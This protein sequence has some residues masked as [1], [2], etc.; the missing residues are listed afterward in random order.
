MIWCTALINLSERLSRIVLMELHFLLFSWRPIFCCSLKRSM[1]CVSSFHKTRWFSLKFERH[2]FYCNRFFVPSSFLAFNPCR[3]FLMPV[4][5]FISFVVLTSIP[6]ISFFQYSVH[7]Y[8][9]GQK[10][11]LF[12][13]ALGETGWYSTLTAV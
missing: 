11:P 3:S 7:R 12:W 1:N 13:A 10:L 2:L 6:W 4:Y 8:L 9:Q 5:S